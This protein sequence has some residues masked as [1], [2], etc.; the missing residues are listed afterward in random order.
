M[1]GRGG[2]TRISSLLLQAPFSHRAGTGPRRPLVAW[3][4]GG[5]QEGTIPLLGVATRE[6]E[7]S[8][9]A[10]P[11]VQTR[12]KHSPFLPSVSD[13]RLGPLCKAG[14]SPLE[15]SMATIRKWQVLP[16]ACGQLPA[17]PSCRRTRGVLG[18]DPGKRAVLSQ[19]DTPGG[20]TSQSPEYH[21]TNHKR[22]PISRNCD[23]EDTNSAFG[24]SLVVCS[25]V[26]RTASMMVLRTRSSPGGRPA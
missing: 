22:G 11:L 24:V 6:G 15:R 1:R 21:T 9:W 7:R 4:A 10:L 23:H 25:V 16:V 8:N 26:F 5:G 17:T 14:W 19:T 20:Q 2:E 12:S 3:E 18:F 13:G